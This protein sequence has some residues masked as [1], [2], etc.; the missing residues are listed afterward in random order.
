MSVLTETAAALVG[1]GKGI[2]AADESVGTM[3]SRLEKAGVAPTEENRRA[4]RE[5]LV[6]TPGLAAWG[7]RDHF[8][9]RNPAAAA[10]R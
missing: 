7:E 2:L 3:S 6:L 5:L 1:G 4:Y 10:V 8:L 9:R